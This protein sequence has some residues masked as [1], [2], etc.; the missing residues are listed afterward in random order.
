VT[1]T[2][3]TFC[4]VCEPSCGLVAE[5]DDG[6]LVGVRPDHDHPVT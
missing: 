4:R 2:V 3:R 5:V 6:V 1:T